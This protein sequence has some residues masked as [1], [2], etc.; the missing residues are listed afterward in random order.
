M[1]DTYMSMTDR[2]VQKSIALLLTPILVA[3]DGENL[4]DY[5]CHGLVMKMCRGQEHNR[6]RVNKFLSN[7]SVS[8]ELPILT[9]EQEKW[10]KST[11][12][13]RHDTLVKQ[14]RAYATEV[15][16]MSPN[17]IAW[18]AALIANS[19]GSVYFSDDF[20]NDTSEHHAQQLVNAKVLKSTKGVDGCF[21]VTI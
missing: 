19:K 21:G 1:Y 4:T 18:M 9:D 14:A 8:I 17:D 5:A 10:W 7:L 3:L 6:D 2:Q 12:D 13:K 16:H 20:L 15:S 11:T